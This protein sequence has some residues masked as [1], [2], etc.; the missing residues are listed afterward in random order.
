MQKDW[1]LTHFDYVF[2]HRELHI[3]TTPHLYHPLD[4]EFAPYVL[5]LGVD[6]NMTF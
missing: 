1:G 3:L 2:P 4:P 5:I 6:A